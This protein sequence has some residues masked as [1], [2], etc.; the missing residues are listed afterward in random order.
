MAK[1]KISLN[2]NTCKD[3]K[4]LDFIAQ[5]RRFDGIELKFKR[6]KEALNKNTT[7]KDVM[8]LSEVYDLEVSSLFNLKDFSLCSEREYKI[9]ILPIFNQMVE[10][11]TKLE[12]DLLIVTPSNLEAPSNGN[13]IPQ[14]R[15]INRTTKRLEDLSKKAK[16]SDLKIGFEYLPSVDCSIA[17]LNDAKDVLNPLESRENVGY[18]IDTFS[19]VKNNVDFNQLHDIK[20]LIWLVQLSDIKYESIDEL[21]DIDESDRI[22]PG[23][24][25]FN[26][27]E[28]II[29][30][31]K[32]RYKGK[33]SLELS[34]EECPKKAHE[35][36]YS[37]VDGIISDYWR[38]S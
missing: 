14:W 5:A 33:Y 16:K 7:L 13:A 10:Y 26:W 4:L 27:K 19:L 22:F 20:E 34:Q 23:N 29:L 21:S 8:E 9:R 37:L 2:Q 15:I 35:K 28:F 17:T 36:I 24:G 12:C 6:I 30:L 3:L 11:C 32:L 18:I 25:A 38:T 31:Q 1:T